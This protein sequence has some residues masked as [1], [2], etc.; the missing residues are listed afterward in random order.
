MFGLGTVLDDSECRRKPSQRVGEYEFH[1]EYTVACRCVGFLTRFLVA[2]MR[3]DFHSG[4]LV[5]CRQALTLKQCFEHLIAAL[6][7]SV[8]ACLQAT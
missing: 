8:G 6:R 7:F 5:P 3:R 2:C 1:R 4:F